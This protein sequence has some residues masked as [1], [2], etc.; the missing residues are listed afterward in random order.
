[1]AYMAL[2]L[3][4]MVGCASS[5]GT[6]EADDNDALSSAEA[7]AATKSCGKSKYAAAL[8]K[9]KQAV[10]AAKVNNSGG[11]CTEVAAPGGAGPKVRA[12]EGNV[13]K[14]MLDAAALC[15]AFGDSIYSSS[16]YAAPVRELLASSLFSRFLDGRISPDSWQ[17]LE[18]GIIG[19]RM[20]SAT[21]DVEFLQGGALTFSAGDSPAWDGSYAVD[22]TT[23]EPLLTIT[24]HGDGSTAVYKLVYRPA[25]ADIVLA[26]VD[27][28][29]V[30][31]TDLPDIVSDRNSCL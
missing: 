8:Q 12:S 4:C 19:V 28:K 31:R 11:A 1:M 26:A 16:V 27:G 15:A 29:G 10:L 2:A 18:T 14:L 3:A 25:V 21:F 23:G 6:G 24:N 13:G 5:Q 7:S 30:F 17:G 22:M 9:Y 20:Y